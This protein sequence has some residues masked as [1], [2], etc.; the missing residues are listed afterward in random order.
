MAEDKDKK[1]KHKKPSDFSSTTEFLSQF[2]KSVVLEDYQEIEPAEWI[3]TGNYL[4]NAHISGSLLKGAASNRIITIGGDPKTGKSYLIYNLMRELIK[5]GYII[6]LNETEGALDKE[7]LRNQG[8]DLTKIMFPPEPP[9]TVDDILNPAI[10]MTSILLADKRA[11]KPI[12]KIAI[13]TDSYTALNSAK[14]YADAEAGESKQDMGT[15]A[16]DLKKFFNMLS[17]RCNY[18]QIPIF[19]TCHVYD[20][21]MGNFRKKVPTGG[22]GAIF[23]SS[24]ITLLTKND[25]RDEDKQR[26]GIFINSEIV[27]SRFSLPKNIRIYL[28]FHKGMNPYWGLQNFVSWSICGI[29]RGKFVDL[30]DLADELLKKKMFTIG[31]FQSPIAKVFTKKDL[32]FLAKAKSE[33]LDE[34]IAELTELGYVKKINDTEYS[35]TSKI[36]ERLYTYDSV[37]AKLEKELNNINVELKKA[38][39][40]KIDITDISEAAKVLEGKI[41]A[42]KGKS[43]DE[44]KEVR[45]EPIAGVVGIANPKSG[46]WIVKHL[47]KVV[48]DVELLT[49]QVFTQ[50]VLKAL[51]D[52]VIRPMFEFSKDKV[53]DLDEVS[54]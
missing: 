13:V 24:V 30:V 35:F 33:Y 45:Y 18:L 7:R 36:K 34:Q 42:L 47:G 44:R 29:D 25:D 49:D 15:V 26:I 46:Q 19:G 43:D 48:K 53:K 10:Q 2:N 12:P 8:L 1:P 5:M 4:Y 14:Q 28:P 27:E 41:S 6:M 50:E 38:E 39:K 3:H 37:I 20:K 40:E 52:K 17:A 51:D 32:S 23:L 22:N 31:E 11:G 21:D 9:E 16:K 54:K